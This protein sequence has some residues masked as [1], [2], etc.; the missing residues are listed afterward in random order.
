MQ[1]AGKGILTIKERTMNPIDYWYKKYIALKECERIPKRELTWHDVEQIILAESNIL[2]EG[3][4]IEKF[5]TA[6]D[7]YSEVLRRFYEMKK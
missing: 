2:A 7:Y 1:S 6:K 4:T 3:A 5:P